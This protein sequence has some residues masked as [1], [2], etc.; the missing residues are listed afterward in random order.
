MRPLARDHRAQ[1]LF[2]QVDP[3]VA[4]RILDKCGPFHAEG[5]AAAELV[6]TTAGHFTQLRKM[7]MGDL[8][9]Q[10]DMW[11]VRKRFLE[12]QGI[13]IHGSV[14][15]VQLR[16]SRANLDINHIRDRKNPDA[17][18]FDIEGSTNPP[19]WTEPARRPLPN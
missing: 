10:R 19:I 6:P 12:S 18:Q 9:G 11:I 8:L 17:F 7:L 15:P 5:P 4:Q 16:G 2:G 3:P 13:R 1:R 14:H